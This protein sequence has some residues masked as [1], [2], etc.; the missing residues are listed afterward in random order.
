MFDNMP[1]PSQFEGGDGDLTQIFD[2][3]RDLMGLCMLDDMP[4]DVSFMLTAQNAIGEIVETIEGFGN[5]TKPWKRADGLTL[6]ISHMREEW[7]DVLFFWVQGA[8]QLGMS[9]E[10]VR[11]EY[12]TKNIKNF[13]RVQEKMG[14]LK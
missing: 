2:L 8:I 6:D 7:V 1:D 14:L 10:D 3:Q 13:V 5:A 12:I 4:K 9:S 11:T